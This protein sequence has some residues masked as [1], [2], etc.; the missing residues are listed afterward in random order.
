[1]A[2]IAISLSD[3]FGQ[4]LVYYLEHTVKLTFNLQKCASTLFLKKQIWRP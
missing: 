2:V 3:P 4:M 1:M